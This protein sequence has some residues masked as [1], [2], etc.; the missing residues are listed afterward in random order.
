MVRSLASHCVTIGQASDSL[1]HISESLPAKPAP[2][3]QLPYG[4]SSS[5]KL[6][7]TG[8]AIESEQHAP[9]YYGRG[10]PP[11]T[12]VS[13]AG[14]SSLRTAAT[15]DTMD[16][17]KGG[18][19]FL[20]TQQPHESRRSSAAS[21]PKKKQEMVE[22][23]NPYSNSASNLSRDRS[24]LSSVADE[25]DVMIVEHPDLEDKA[26]K[27]LVGF[28]QIPTHRSHMLTLSS[29]SSLD[30]ALC[31]QVFFVS[32]HSWQLSFYFWS[33]LSVSVTHGARS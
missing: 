32:T 6:K 3:A 20:W 12:S 27:I 9:Y 14:G 29:C 19:T 13:S 8:C 26:I 22:W 28:L 1:S 15:V 18:P 16:P 5:S 11:G 33:T 24:S 4:V 17:E 7:Y 10:M 2:A 25:E 31:S 23:N 21:K 30:P